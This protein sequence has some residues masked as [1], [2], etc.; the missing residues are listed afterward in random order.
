MGFVQH[1]GRDP[2]EDCVDPRVRQIAKGGA[3]LQHAVDMGDRGVEVAKF[4]LRL[5]G[6][7]LDEVIVLQEFRLSIALVDTV[8]SALLKQGRAVGRECA[9]ESGD[10]R[11]ETLLEI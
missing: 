8:L 11:K 2:V 4:G 10:R 3:D 6:H 9:V 1:L 7:D 5:V